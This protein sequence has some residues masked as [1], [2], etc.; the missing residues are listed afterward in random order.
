MRI[1]AGHIHHV[2]IVAHQNLSGSKIPEYRDFCFSL[3][4]K[5]KILVEFIY[6]YHP[7]HV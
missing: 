6:I 1:C 4:V 2:T 3:R 7:F 5:K